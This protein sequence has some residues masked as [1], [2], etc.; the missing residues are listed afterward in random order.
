MVRRALHVDAF[1]SDLSFYQYTVRISRCVG[2]DYLAT[3]FSRRRTLFERLDGVALVLDGLDLSGKVALVTGSSKGIGAAIARMYAEHGAKVMITSRQGD[4]LS[5][6][7]DS[8]DG[9]V[10]FVAGNAGDPKHAHSCIKSTIDRF[11]RLDILVNNAATNPHY[12]RL[13]DI[14]LSMLD[15]IFQVNLRGPLIWIQEAWSQIMSDR[16]GNILNISSVGALRFNSPIG[17]Y[18]MTKAALIHM[19]KHLAS[20]LGPGV[21][22]NAIAPG[23]VRTDFARPLWESGSDSDWAWPLARLGEPE[24]V[25]GAAL[26]LVSDLAAWLTGDVLVVDGGALTRDGEMTQSNRTG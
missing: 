3:G 21:R 20:E 25:A 1:V 10:S 18:D 16:G 12:G 8:I 15:K 7:A 9:E 23:L 4:A 5:R 6:M 24:D 11:G 13:I 22:V 26:F 17:A 2:S 14:D 19:T